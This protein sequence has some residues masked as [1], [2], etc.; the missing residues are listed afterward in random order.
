M[1]KKKLKLPK[2]YMDPIKKRRYI[3]IGKRKIWIGKQV[4]MKELLKFILKAHRKRKTKG[5][6]KTKGEKVS[7][8]FGDN[9]SK[10]ANVDVIKLAAKEAALAQ[11]RFDQMQKENRLMLKASEHEEDKV[12]NKALEKLLS[13]M[14]AEKVRL[15]LG[16]DKE[17]DKL[18]AADFRSG[19][20]MLNKS[21]QEIAKRDQE[22]RAMEKE[23]HAREL[24]AE[25]RKKQ[26]AEKKNKLK[27]AEVDFLSIV[28]EH[29]FK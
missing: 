22:L 12:A 5:K 8:V 21:Q 13:L 15:L 29:R 23:R 24:A 19:V 14:P 25:N 11:N 20:G 10:T 18:G 4:T 16:A 3:V 28:E 6:A 27:V 17:E 26:L 9:I 2:V 1:V 7:R